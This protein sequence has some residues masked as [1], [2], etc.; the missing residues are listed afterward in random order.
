M[1]VPSNPVAPPIILRTGW[2]TVTSPVI[3]R[4]ICEP[5]AMTVFAPVT[6]RRIAAALKS[7]RQLMSGNRKNRA[8]NKR[9]ASR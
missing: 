2:G 8:K 3:P 4:F 9:K 5:G 7:Y 1:S 6:N